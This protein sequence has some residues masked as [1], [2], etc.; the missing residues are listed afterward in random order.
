MIEVQQ[1]RFFLPLLVYV[2]IL[3]SV[4]CVVAVLG[5]VVLGEPG[6]EP[7]ANE[8]TTF[9]MRLEIPE[10]RGQASRRHG[11]TGLHAVEA[12][13]QPGVVTRG[14]HGGLEVQD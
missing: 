3:A 5:P 1:K 10:I 7:P 13:I 2:A 11:E 14:P 6:V 4:I 12:E 9:I 8:R